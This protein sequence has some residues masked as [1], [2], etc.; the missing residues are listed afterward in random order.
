MPRHPPNA[1]TSRLRVHTTNNSAGNVNHRL[2]TTRQ[3][4]PGQCGLKSQPCINDRPLV[5]PVRRPNKT[6]ARHGIDLK[7][8]FTMSNSCGIAA[9]RWQTSGSRCF[10]IWI[11]AEAARY[12]GQVAVVQVVSDT[13]AA[14]SVAAKPR[15]VAQLGRAGRP[16]RRAN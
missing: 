14:P 1:L 15:P 11:M 6:N 7:N 12:G 10:I 9:Y 8:P 13:S 16:C 4:L 3:T 2:T 5:P